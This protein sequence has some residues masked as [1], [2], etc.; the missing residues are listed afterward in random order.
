VGWP[1][2]QT[3]EGME[4]EKKA[5]KKG[6]TTKPCEAN[7]NWTA[8]RKKKPWENC[9]MLF[10][11]QPTEEG[12]IRPRV[13]KRIFV[14]RKKKKDRWSS[15]TAYTGRSPKEGLGRNHNSKLAG[16]LQGKNSPKEETR[17]K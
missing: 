7:K 2:P 9:L 3:A 11:N 16:G 17:L 10:P 12:V 13:G 14:K 4:G 8:D 6:Q 1:K 5:K 15:T